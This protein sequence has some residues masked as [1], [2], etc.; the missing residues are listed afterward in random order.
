MGILDGIMGQVAGS[1]L[2][3]GGQFGQLG[4]LVSS[5]SGGN[6]AQA[7]SLLAAAAA[8]VQ[9][10]GGLTEV[11]AKFQ[12]AGL[13]TEAQSWVG[14]G[15]NAGIS[16][17]QLTSALGGG[18]IDQVASQLGMSSG[19]ASSTLAQLLPEIINQL[20]PQGQVPDNHADL[21][22]QGLAL[23]KKGGF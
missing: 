13:G 10:N 1:L 19:Q 23:L 6:P 18:A 15:A 12:Q 3:G 17:D 7:G 14:T 20:T 11:L 5:L 2:G 16:G 9:Q 8:L 22:A 4:S 21:L